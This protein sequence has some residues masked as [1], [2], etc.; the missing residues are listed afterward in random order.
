[1][2]R[3]WS[4]AL[5]DFVLYLTTIYARD[6]AS[7]KVI[8]RFR[9]IQKQFLVLFTRFKRDVYAST[10][11][12]PHLLVRKRSTLWLCEFSIYLFSFSQEVT[13]L[14]LMKRS[15][16]VLDSNSAWELIYEELQYLDRRKGFDT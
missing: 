9:P 11:P 7:G 12:E 6:E 4:G 3:D 5:E 13:S 14:D 15:G 16:F 8:C 1:M 10:S 2:A